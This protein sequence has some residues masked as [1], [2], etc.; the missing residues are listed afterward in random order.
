MGKESN[1]IVGKNHLPYVQNQIKV[2][3]KILGKQDKSNSDIVWANGRTSWVRLVSSV[4]IDGGEVPRYDKETGENFVVFSFEGAQF[5]ERY[6]GLATENYAGNRLASE[7][8]LHGGAELNGTQRFGIASSTSTLPGIQNSTKDGPA[9]YGLGGTEFGL[10]PMPGV[11][12]FSTKDYNN[13]TFR[14]AFI[15]I[16][17]NNKVQFQYIEA[18]YMRLGYNMLIEWGN[19]T[20][21]KTE[22]NY[23]SQGDIASLSLKDDFLNGKDVGLDYFYTKINQNR[24]KSF[25]NYDGFVGQVTNFKWSF[26]TD[27]TYNITLDLVSVGTIIDSL[28]ISNPLSNISLLGETF[29]ELSEEE[30]K[31]VISKNRPS[32]LETYLEVV[33]NY[34]LVTLDQDVQQGQDQTSVDVI[35]VI[36]EDIIANE[37]NRPENQLTDEERQAFLDSLPQN[38]EEEPVEEPVETPANSSTTTEPKALPNNQTYKSNLSEKDKKILGGY[39]STTY[40]GCR[41]GFGIGTEI[42]SG[43][44]KTVSYIRFGELLNFINKRLLI[45]SP[46]TDKPLIAI[47]INEELY[48]YSNGWQF[49]S[50]PLKMI[51]RFEQNFGNNAVNNINLLPELP[52]FHDTVEGVQVGRLMNLY[53]STEYLGELIRSNL[54]TKDDLKLYPFLRD[55]IDTANRLLGQRNKLSLRVVEKTFTERIIEETSIPDLDPSFTNT[56]QLTEVSFVDKS[57][58]KQV[59]EIYDEV[60]PYGREK[61]FD[62]PEANPP[63][64]VYGFNKALNEGNFV[65]DYSFTTSLT[66]EYNAMITIGAQAAGR[67]IGMDATV[68]SNWNTGL[69]DRIVPRK[70]D[71]DEVILDAVTDRVDFRKLASEYKSLLSQLIRTTEYQVPTGKG[72]GSL[73]YTLPNINV[74]KESNKSSFATNFNNIQTEFFNKGLSYVALTENIQTPF[75]GFLPV[76]FTVTLDGISGVRIFDKLTVN[77]DFLPPNYEKTLDFII[78]AVDHN[79]QNNKWYTTLRTLGLP[80]LFGN[81]EV[82]TAL[83]IANI[84][85]ET[86]VDDDRITNSLDVESYFY[87]SVPLITQSP[88]KVTVNQIL[89]GLNSSTEI[90]SRFEN[91]LNGLLKTIPNGFEIRINSAYRNFIDSDRVYKNDWPVADTRFTKSLSSPHTYGLALDISLWEPIPNQPGGST[92][93][94]AGKAEQYFPKWVDLG[95]VD[96][97]KEKGLRWG[98]TFTNK[99]GSKY[100]DCVHFDATPAFTTNW[101]SSSIS[102]S[103]KINTTY[104]NI[105]LVMTYGMKYNFRDFGIGD[106]IYN[107]SLKDFL[108]IESGKIDKFNEPI[109]GTSSGAKGILYKSILIDGKLEY[110]EGDKKVNLYNL[111]TNSI[112]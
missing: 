97:A 13:G 55:I 80:K 30:Q 39:E 59:I 74:I 21:P 44:S 64:N 34:G 75:V 112:G 100:Y 37:L 17:A 73:I 96:L 27:G 86:S 66:N 52:K 104:P 47:D 16:R 26:E 25:A 9:S 99:D 3:Q 102:I 15:T 43:P 81:T 53:I 36:P 10:V 19:S 103:D 76:D 83:E 18:L 63:I 32:A 91:F 72:G 110:F 61:L 42:N 28:K 101:P 65:T 23:S 48:C 12:S 69:V 95:I 109:L 89:Q 106:S 78:M 70:L 111:L 31:E 6:L 108:S 68:F 98:G 22:N 92:N 94:L 29:K 77:T 5:R 84:V 54:D 57:I 41:V 8:P 82:K 35:D 79:I 50:D 1:N 88:G 51:I 58:T 40:V 4:D 71:Y 2:R 56:Q 7:L 90:Q 93:R 45:Y 49:P 60:Q 11:T 105:K 62:N 67:A 14:K 38:V 33:S 20:Y 107:V 87:S 46:T 85:N 24:A